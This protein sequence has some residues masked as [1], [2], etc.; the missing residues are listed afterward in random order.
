MRILFINTIQMFGGGEVWMLRSLKALR[1]RGHQ[2]F[3]LC[4]PGVL[5]EQRAKE[6]GIRVF[7]FQ[8]RGDFGPL[9]ILRT[10]RLI[11]RENIQIIL[12]N[13]EKELRFSGVAA[14]LVGNCV[15]ISR[16][17]IDHPLKNK[18]RYRFTYNVLA[19]GIIAN[20]RATKASL[21][22]NAPWLNPDRI[23]VIYNGIDPE[24]FLQ[25]PVYDL[26]EKLG[27]APQ[28]R[29]IGFVGQLDERK[30][31][32]TLLASFE[33]VASENA[34]VHL[35][36][37][38]EGAKRA[39][40]EQF[41]RQHNL[42][43]RIHLLGFQKDI[44]DIMKGIDALVLPSLWEGFGIVLIEAMAAGKPAITT[45]VSSMPEIVV[46]NET[47]RVVPVNDEKA[48]AAAMQQIVRNPQLARQWGAK[49]RQRVLE[50]FTIDRMID[51]LEDYFRRHIDKKLKVK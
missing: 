36:L 42:T 25:P 12:N 6:A 31:I 26:K 20:S 17:G 4:R 28:A 27:L 41:A 14:K 45:N 2:V 23:K 47:G 3:L 44:T 16:R 39:A 51:E 22:K 35:V 13:M 43:A 7:T 32:D 1:D 50:L 34:D 9:S 8:V 38:G 48:L 5:L 18:L 37:A 33:I 19:D 29:I 10:A 46:D 40:I 30:G 24:P 15:V 21:L 49:G 11:K